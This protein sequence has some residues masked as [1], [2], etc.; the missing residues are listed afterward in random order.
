M[1]ARALSVNW[2]QIEVSDEAWQ[3]SL[4]IHPDLD[5]EDTLDAISSP[6]EIWRGKDGKLYVVRHCA[7]GKYLIV[8]YTEDKEA[9]NFVDAFYSNKPRTPEMKEQL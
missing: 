3:R 6:D 5:L 1:I 8:V 4:A 2:I 9:G 7:E